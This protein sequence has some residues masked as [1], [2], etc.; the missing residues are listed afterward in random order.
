VSLICVRGV[1]VVGSPLPL[2]PSPRSRQPEQLEHPHYIYDRTPPTSCLHSDGM[3]ANAH[4]SSRGFSSCSC[5]NVCTGAIFQVL[6]VFTMKYLQSECGYTFGP[7]HGE[8]EVYAANRTR[9]VVRNCLDFHVLEQ[10]VWQV[11]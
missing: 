5:L 4:S 1:R 9:Y 10:V 2:F 11:Q 3:W 7:S 6:F 8:L